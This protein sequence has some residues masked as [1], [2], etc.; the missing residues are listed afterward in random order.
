MELFQLHTTLFFQFLFHRFA[1]KICKEKVYKEKWQS[2][3]VHVFSEQF[4]LNIQNSLFLFN[5][6]Q[7]IW[8]KHYLF[9]LR[10]LVCYHNIHKWNRSVIHRPEMHDFSFLWS[11]SYLHCFQYPVH[12]CVWT[13]LPKA[14]LEVNWF[15]LLLRVHMG[16]W[17]DLQ[18]RTTENAPI[19]LH[20]W[21][22]D[23]YNKFPSCRW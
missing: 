12:V 3:I 6:Q 20:L 9:I 14:I 15:A 2:I 21:W 5:Y 13:C 17:V 18:L 4:H 8:F 23:F 1:A 22:L 7:P 10:W 11:R 16:M 19:F